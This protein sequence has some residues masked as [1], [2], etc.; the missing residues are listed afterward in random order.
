MYSNHE[1]RE[2]FVAGSRDVDTCTSSFKFLFPAVV[3]GTLAGILFMGL[4]TYCLTKE[5]L[6]ALPVDLIETL[7]A[8]VTR[9]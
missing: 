6:F 1:K 5:I 7:R 9:Q 2:D 4:E 8:I 3:L